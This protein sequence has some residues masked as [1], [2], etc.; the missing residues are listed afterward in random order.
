MI[1]CKAFAHLAH[2][3]SKNNIILPVFCSDGGRITNLATSPTPKNDIIFLGS[4]FQFSNPLPCPFD[5]GGKR[6]EIRITSQLGT[7]I[8]EEL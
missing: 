2:W 7:P 8:H 1:F 5:G 4:Y 3:P 6:L